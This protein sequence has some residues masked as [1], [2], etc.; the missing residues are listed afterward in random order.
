LI[1]ELEKSGART[2]LFF[3]DQYVMLLQ[4]KGYFVQNQA[5]Y[6]RLPV[7]VL[8]GFLGTIVEDD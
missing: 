4:L 7:T 6:N 1:A 3:S 8:S 5:T 2:P